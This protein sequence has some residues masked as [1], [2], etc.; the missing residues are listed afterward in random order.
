LP[1]IFKGS[2]GS[3]LLLDSPHIAT[4]KQT[5]IFALP[6]G[7]NC[8]RGPQVPSFIIRLPAG[9]QGFSRKTW[10]FMDVGAKV[11]EIA[12]GK[13]A[14]PGHFIVTVKFLDRQRPARLIVI[15]DGDNGVTIDACAELSRQLSKALDEQDLLPMAY[16]L[17]VSTPGLD[18]PLQLKRQYRKNVG[19][20]LKVHLVNKQIVQ[21]RLES[22]TEDKVVIEEQVKNAVSKTT[23]IAYGDIEKAFVMV[24][25]K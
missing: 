15:V 5:A 16:T 14:D 3:K 4:H 11:R 8:K 1:P 22:A 9:R 20:G 23:E 18:H 13:L 19:R 21:G 6:S 25:F 2:E 12:E 10:N 7:I 17:E 24:S